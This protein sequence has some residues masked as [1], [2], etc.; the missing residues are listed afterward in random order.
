MTSF[1]AVL[2]TVRID[3]RATG[4]VKAQGA[5]GSVIHLGQMLDTGRVLTLAFLASANAANAMTSPRTCFPGNG[6]ARE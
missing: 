5:L 1:F 2:G 3:W 6:L 4:E